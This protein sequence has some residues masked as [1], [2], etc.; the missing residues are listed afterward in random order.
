M[1]NTKDKFITFGG[2]GP[3]TLF[4]LF[5]LAAEYGR[6][7]RV[8]SMD[9]FLM[10]TTM[11]MVLTLPYFLPSRFEKPSFAHWLIARSCVAIT[12]VF[13]GVAFRQSLG[14]VLPESVRLLPLTFLVM[15]SMVSC[16]IQFYGLL[17]LRPAK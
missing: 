12:A 15:A 3:D 7:V 2:I 10:G 17:R 5:F 1:K 4:V 8:L 9:G 11:I 14:V 6:A 13:L 16:Y